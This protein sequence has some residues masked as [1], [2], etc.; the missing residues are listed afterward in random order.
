MP[1]VIFD[2][3]GTLADTLNIGIAVFR[4]LSKK[5]RSMDDRQMEELRSFSAQQVLKR[6]GIRWWQ[7]PLLVYRARKAVDEHMS[8]GQVSS[9]PGVQDVLEDLHK[10]GYRLFIAS[11]NSR[12]NIDR[13]L[14]T[15]GFEKY[16]EKIYGG[17]G[18]FSKAS[19]LKSIVVQNGL[20]LQD[21]VYVGDEA[22][23]VDAVRK[24]GMRCVS[25]TWGYNNRKALTA[26]KAKVI[27]DTPAELL[28][29]IA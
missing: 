27:V 2:F 25:V 7:L 12:R 22:R 28:K 21:C 9:F 23:D 3:D 5:G 8:E 13:F 11:T 24:A 10:Q 29:T 18:L 17:V 16:F 6:M 20:R 15:H 14:K 26:A 19:A 1:N 4:Q